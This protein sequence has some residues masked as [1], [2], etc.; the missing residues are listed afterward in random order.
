MGCA[1]RGIWRE[2]RE[3]AR[4]ILAYKD[5]GTDTRRKRPHGKGGLRDP[6][7]TRDHQLPGRVE[8]SFNQPIMVGEIL[9]IIGRM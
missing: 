4:Q 1:R 2:H 7:E 3:A 9:A 8:G 6:G 5:P